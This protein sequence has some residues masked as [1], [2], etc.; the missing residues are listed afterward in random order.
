MMDSG[1]KPVD[2]KGCH[3]Y[4]ALQRRTRPLWGRRS[5][6]AFLIGQPIPGTNEPGEDACRLFDIV[7]F[8]EGTCGRRPGLR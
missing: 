1:K 6:R 4:M 2:G 7:G 5:F 8:D 3:T